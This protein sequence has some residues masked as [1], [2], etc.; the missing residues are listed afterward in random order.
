MEKTMEIIRKNVHEIL[1]KY[2]AE[3]L[4]WDI[5]HEIMAGIE[6]DLAHAEDD[7]DE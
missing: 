3:R 2:L 7:S 1:D 4:T 6:W 5:E